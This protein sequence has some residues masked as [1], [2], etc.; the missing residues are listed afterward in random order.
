[1]STRTPRIL[2][3][4]AWLL[5]FGLGAGLLQPGPGLAQGQVSQAGV[6]IQFGDGSVVTQCV[7]F[8]GGAI[9][10]LELIQRAGLD[11]V[12]AFDP[13]QGAAVCRIGGDGCPSE[14]C[15]CEFPKYWSYWHLSGSGWVYSPAGSSSYNVPAGGV[16]G[17]RWGQGDPP[18]VIPFAQ[19]CQAAPTEAPP[20]A[21]LL[22]PSSTPEPPTATPSIP[23]AVEPSPT[24][25]PTRTPQPDTPTPEF[26][27]SETPALAP[28]ALLPSPS[29]SPSASPSPTA[30]PTP[31]A[32]AAIPATPTAPTPSASPPPPSS[33]PRPSAAP[34]NPA[35][36]ASVP[37]SAGR[38]GY[39]V[40]GALFF[41]LGAGLLVT[42]A[43]QRR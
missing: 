20:T 39:L 38:L 26:T 15:F 10:G 41:A 8:Q 22:S 5:L 1:M 37:Q 2:A 4:L 28:L 36:A 25:R 24:R 16:D 17:W 14:S 13:S 9:S 31:T 29:A 11:V 33:T 6:V 40:F 43:L 30:S 18:P 21:T 34:S 19:I 7:D 23:P 3:A 27:A 32:S 35:P 42:L 12:T